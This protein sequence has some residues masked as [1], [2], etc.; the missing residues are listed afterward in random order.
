MNS[1]SAA[2][3][4][5]RG[6]RYTPLRLAATPWRMGP[7]ALIAYEAL[8]ERPPAAP[9]VF[10]SLWVP[11]AE[12][13]PLTPLELPGG[14]IGFYVEARGEATRLLVEKPPLRAGAVAPMG[15]PYEP[16]LH[17]SAVLAAPG[18]YLAHLV[19]LARLLSSRGEEILILHGLPGPG[20]GPPPR[21][22]GLEAPGVEYRVVEPAR[23]PGEAVEEA[24]ARGAALYAAGPEEMLCRLHRLAEGAGILERTTFALETV[25]RCGMGFCG[26]CR[27]PGTRWLLCRDG[28][29]YP[30]PALAAWRMRVCGAASAAT[31]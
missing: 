22:L 25:V 27:V 5:P 30:A 7:A 9:G 1:L 26:R 23:L 20:Y 10:L 31:S 29:F 21:L 13:V 3:S 11:G 15:A 12:A 6:Y 4:R 18:A 8:G 17:G 19:S 14:L 16:P 24:S 28:V 2:R